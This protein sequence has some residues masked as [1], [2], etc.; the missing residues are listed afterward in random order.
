MQAST[1]HVL[2][3]ARPRLTGAGVPL[4]AAGGGAGVVTVW[5]LEERKL[6]HDH[7]RRARRADH[8]PA[9]FRRGAAPAERWGGQ[10]REAVGAGRRGRL[11][12]AAAL[13]VRARRSADC[14]ALLRRLRHAP[15]VCWWV[16]APL[17]CGD[18][19]LS[20][21]NHAGHGRAAKGLE[22]LQ[23]ALLGR[24]SSCERCMRQARIAR[25]ACSPRSR[26]S[27]ARS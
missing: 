13:Q 10:R 17:L 3:R 21:H 5:N 24:Y 14:R 1:V 20:I 19:G 15:A 23:A 27:R 18:H 25:S 7:S 11:G 4:M 9:L 22:T 2:I 16:S 26:T 12:K 8:G 6:H